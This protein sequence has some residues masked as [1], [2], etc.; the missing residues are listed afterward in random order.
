MI[1]VVLID[2]LN[3]I[4]RIYA[5]QER[6]YLPLPDTISDNTRKQLQHNTINTVE[7]AVKKI[8]SQLEPS[9]AVM[10]FDHDV[11]HSWRHKLY[12]E[13]KADRKPMPAL[14]HST[15]PLIKSCLAEAGVKSISPHEYEADDVIASLA[16][17]L[18]EKQHQAIIV[19]T[20]KGFLPI[21]Q[22][23]LQIYDHFKKA[24]VTDE[25]IMDKFGVSKQKL[26][27]YWALVGDSTN[28]IKGIA[29]IGPKT[30]IEILTNHASLKA[31]V[32]DDSLSK[33]AKQALSEQQYS[34]KL[35]A[36]LLA[37]KTDVDLGINLK[38][39]RLGTRYDTA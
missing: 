29:G 33:K 7:S 17:K 37:P 18:V 14:L 16:S 19:S 2:A 6:P 11:K 5:V 20:D 21:L 12:P 35:A 3:L 32:Q 30:A 4:R 24:F 38:N 10:V 22:N 8:I 28:N 25:Y 39:Y 31:A 26:V 23:N 1:K 13:Y 15:L 36:T 9:H 34:F 27:S